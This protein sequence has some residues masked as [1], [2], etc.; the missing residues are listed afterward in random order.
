MMGTSGTDATSWGAPGR[1]S[2]GWGAP[3]LPRRPAALLLRGAGRSCNTG[4]PTGGLH[5]IVGTLISVRDRPAMSTDRH[6]GVRMP[7]GHG[8]SMP[9]CLVDPG[10]SAARVP[11]RRAH[12]TPTT[13]RGSDADVGGRT[14]RRRCRGWRRPESD[15][16]WPVTGVAHRGKRDRFSGSHPGFLPARP[17]MN[18]L[19]KFYPTRPYRAIAAHLVRWQ[20][21]TVSC[22]QCRGTGRW[23]SSRR[24]RPS[25]RRS[26]ANGSSRC[27]PVPARASTTA[28][29]GHS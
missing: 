17:P 14:L 10:R 28:R 23:R 22:R 29:P 27:P 2:A 11:P 13:A 16:S 25:A 26:S 18:D 20:Q 6:E 8:A 9:R 15:A 21:R 12:P 5:N 4:R 3:G 7:R 1:V 19:L 24:L